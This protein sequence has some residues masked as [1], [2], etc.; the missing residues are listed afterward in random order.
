ME[1][2][3]RLG[4]IVLEGLVLLRERYVDI[5]NT[6]NYKCHE[7]THKILG[8]EESEKRGWPNEINMRREKGGS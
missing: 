2:G 7:G 6:S 5:Q 1:I 8:I 4:F 3:K